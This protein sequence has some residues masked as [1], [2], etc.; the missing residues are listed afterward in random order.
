MQTPPPQES[1]TKEQIKG[2][3]RRQK[4]MFLTIFFLVLTISIIVALALP[5]IYRAQSTILIEEQQIPQE[6]V[7]TTITSYVEE[8]LQVITQQ[9]MSRPRL[10]EII[11][12]FNLYPEMRKNHT[13]EE[14]IKKLRDNISLETISADVVDRRTGR[15][16]TA[17]IAFNL[18]YQGEDPDTVVKVTNRLTSLYLEENLRQREERVTNITTFLK[19]ERESLAKQI[20][21]LEENISKFK[22]I[23]GR[24]L[25]EFNAVNLQAVNRLTR[26]LE[27]NRMQ[28]RSL[29]E[30]KLYL[31]G[32]LAT[33]DPSRNPGLMHTDE[34][35]L[36]LP[37]KEKL[38]ALRMQLLSLKARYS[39]KHPDVKK[40]EH[41]IAEIEA[42]HPELA[43]GA[44][45]E[46]SEKREQLKKLEKEEK[47]LAARLG[48]KH[49]DRIR[50][51]KEIKI[52]RREID[53]LSR[54]SRNDAENRDNLQPQEDATNPA[55]INLEVQLKSTELEIAAT[56]AEYRETKKK[57]AEYQ[58][59]L[60]N[61]PLVERDYNRLS[62]DLEQAQQRYVDLSHKLT[63]AQVARQMEEAQ[64]GERFKIIDPAQKPEKP[65]KPNRIAIV[66]IGFVLA[67]GLAT[68]VCAL[69]ENLDTSVK[70]TNELA[71]LTGTPVL[72][73]TPL[74]ESPS[75][76]RRRRWR[77][78]LYLCLVA[79]LIIGALAAIHYFYLPL[80]VLWIKIL[81][82]LDL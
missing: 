11:D 23:H 75:E 28:L 59:R 65:F 77:Y 70:S 66:L 30:R 79:A 20:A 10:Q 33:I 51:Q 76:R 82:R 21:Q 62:R 25:P 7:Q 26:D 80:D 63:E 50:L 68:G 47:D 58:A 16:T 31:E 45:N 9:I 52:L 24:E 2:I 74:M 81:R 67:L 57:L 72:S 32:Q 27:Q 4:G 35:R 18:S 1:I 19:Q 38:K 71:R 17:T 49:P 46:L 40:T 44:A 60:E 13:R 6:F 55:Y 41:E 78:I 64:Q 56:E 73:I 69:R 14:I 5:S 8:R 42:L 29:K 37:P 15:P 39:D 12:R 43:Q 48:D 34:G 61:A 54:K 53:E 36:L 3:I 22:Q